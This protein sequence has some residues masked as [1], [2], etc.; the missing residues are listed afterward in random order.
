MKSRKIFPRLTPLL[1]ATL[2]R[3]EELRSAMGML[4]LLGDEVRPATQ[5]VTDLFSFVSS[6]AE[7]LGEARAVLTFM[8]TRAGLPA[9]LVALELP[10]AEAAAAFEPKFRRLVGQEAES[11]QG[12]LGRQ[13]EP[14]RA[15]AARKPAPGGMTVRGAVRSAAEQ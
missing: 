13:S 9:T 11:V 4:T 1:L 10:S 15:P 7:A 14:E 5:P 12:I 6:N 2:A 3:S 8:P